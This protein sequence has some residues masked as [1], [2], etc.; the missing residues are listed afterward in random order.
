M[1]LPRFPSLQ[2]EGCSS[3]CWGSGARS[4][5]GEVAEVV[6]GGDKIEIAPM[7]AHVTASRFHV[8]GVGGGLNVSRKKFVYDA[9]EWAGYAGHVYHASHRYS[10]CNGQFV[11]RS[12][13]PLQRY[14]RDYEPPHLH[15][16]HSP[17]VISSTRGGS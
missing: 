4:C 2:G 3:N 8:M 17:R 16:L 12:I 15:P 14:E 10:G 9:V 13:V 1:P 7:V 6:S 5:G 11:V